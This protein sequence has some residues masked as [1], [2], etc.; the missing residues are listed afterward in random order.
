MHSGNKSCGLMRLKLNF[1]AVMSK[2][3]FGEKREQKF[4]KRTPLQ[5]LE[6]AGRW[7]D[8]ALGLCCSQWHREHFTGRGKNGFK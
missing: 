7:M 2:G 1:L 3:M 4:M 8:H 5:L 6:V